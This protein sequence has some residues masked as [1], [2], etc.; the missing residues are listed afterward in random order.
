[1]F[2]LCVFVCFF[3][4]FFRV[5]FVCLFLEILTPKNKRRNLEILD[6]PCPTVSL[7]GSRVPVGVEGGQQEDLR[8]V[9]QSRDPL[10]LAIP[11]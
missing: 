7:V 2:F 5:F 1:M 4:C 6:V 9:H 8:A 11:R 10:I 3:V